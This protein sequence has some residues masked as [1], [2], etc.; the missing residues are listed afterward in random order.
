LGVGAKNSELL[1]GTK[2][3]N[4]RANEKKGTNSEKERRV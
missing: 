1:V 4:P 3:Q 2:K